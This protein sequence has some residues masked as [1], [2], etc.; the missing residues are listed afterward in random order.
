LRNK[1]FNSVLRTLKIDTQLRQ[2]D[3][4]GWRM[5]NACVANISHLHT[6]CAQ[7]IVTTSSLISK[8]KKRAP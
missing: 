7:N 1:Y 8:A 6:A 4:V 5:Q 2:K 3:A